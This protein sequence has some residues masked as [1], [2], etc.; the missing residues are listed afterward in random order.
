MLFIEANLKRTVHINS[1]TQTGFR[2]PRQRGL[3]LW[4]DCLLELFPACQQRPQAFY[5][6]PVLLAVKTDCKSAS[7]FQILLFLL[8]GDEFRA[9]TAGAL[10]SVRHN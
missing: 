7:P 6:S 8:A 4:L 3:S 9:S 5:S 10:T 2:Y 1:A